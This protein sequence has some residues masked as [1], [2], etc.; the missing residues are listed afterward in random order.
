MTI[1][2]LHQ[3]LTTNRV[4]DAIILDRRTVLS[5]PILLLF[6][7]LLG[8]DSVLIHDPVV[9]DAAADGSFRVVG[10]STVLNLERAPVE[11][12]FQVRG[13]EL[14]V[15]LRL[16]PPEGWMLETS[17][18]SL[19]RGDFAGMRLHG[20]SLS[21]S[22][23]RP[24]GEPATLRDGLILEAKTGV[25]VF[26]PA[27]SPL[28][29]AA[30]RL[31]MRASIAPAI[32]V[33]STLSPL[34]E[35][36]PPAAIDS[37]DARLM[38]H[39]EAGPGTSC[40]V[41]DLTLTDIG[42]SMTGP[43]ITDWTPDAGIHE[44][45]LRNL[46]ATLQVAEREVRLVAGLGNDGDLYFSA[47]LVGFDL[48]GLVDL[49]E[50]VAGAQLPDGLPIPEA[51]TLTRVAVQLDAGT[52][53]VAL[54]SFTV[55]WPATL[56]FA[57]DAL[58]VDNLLVELTAVSPFSDDRFVAVE[59]AGDADWKGVQARVSLYAPKFVARLSM[60]SLDLGAMM[61]LMLGS[62]GSDLGGMPNIQFKFVEAT[63]HPGTGA[64]S[65]RG[66]T[67]V[68]WE[69]PV[70]VSNLSLSDIAIDLDLARDGDGNRQLKGLLSG[71][72]KL[73]DAIC[74]VEHRLP[75]DF[76]LRGQ[77]PDLHLAEVIETLCGPVDVPG[78]DMPPGVFDVNLSDLY[79][80]I[81]P[82]RGT[83]ALAAATPLGDAE[84]QVRR[85][86][87]GR[88]GF[89]IGYAPATDWK[90]SELAA[91][92]AVL[93]GLELSG[94]TLI[95]SSVDDSS[96]ALTTIT[97]SRPDIVLNRDQ[98]VSAQSAPIPLDVQR[99]LNIYSAFNLAGSGADQV[100]GLT[101]LQVFLGVS[102][103]LSDLVLEAKVDG[104]FSIA[105]GVELGDV[106]FRLR[107]APN[108]FSITLLG[109]IT[110]DIE[111][112]L[113]KFTGGLEVQPRG[114]AMQATMEGT[115]HEPFG[116]PRLKLSDVALDLGLS[117]SPP[118]PTL[119]IA[120]K[121]DLGSF[122]GSAAV[123][124]DTINPGRSMLALAFKRLFLM[125]ILNGFC[126][127]DAVRDLPPEVVDLADAIG[128][129]DVDIY[130]APMPTRIG[131]LEFDQ[132][133]SVRGALFLL[134][135][136]G[137]ADMKVDPAAGI[138]AAGSMTPIELG[139]VLAVRGAN[140]D[141]NPSMELVLKRGET[142][143]VAVS[144]SVTMLGMT[145]S[146]LIMMSATAFK[147]SMSGD[148]FG[149]F[150][151]S[152]TA[153]GA[154]IDNAAGI[155]IEATMQNDLF[156]YLS[157]HATTIIDRAADGAVAGLTR[158]QEDVTRLQNEVR[159][160]DRVITTT[161]QQISTERAR[162][163]RKLANAQR[164]LK[165]AQAK[166]NR[167]NQSITNTRRTIQRERSRDQAKVRQARKDVANAQKKVDTLAA[168]I[169][170]TKSG[171]SKLRKK[172][173]DKKRWLNRKSAWDKTWAGPE[174]LAY[175]AAKETEIAALNTKIGGIEAA[176]GVATA[177]LEGAKGVLRGATAG[178]DTFPVDA[179]PR[180]AGLLT[181]RTAA[182]G[183]LKAARLVL[184]G[185]DEAA[186]AVPIDADPRIVGLFTTRSSAL[187]GL[188]SAKGV[189]AGLKAAT[190][191][192]AAAAAFITEHGLGGLI[193]I[194]AISFRAS[195][196][197][198]AGGRVQL[199]IDVSFMRQAVHS[200]GL[201]F[202]F[203]DPLAGAKALAETLVPELRT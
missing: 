6:D 78:L 38:I 36:R 103:R 140:A 128:M 67:N 97:P 176:R 10:R 185:I 62:A 75:G 119:G 164:E 69:I 79:F 63:I 203:K 170:S 27:I 18:P 42:L 65:L 106:G 70:G 53:T 195:L 77:I 13:D 145:R 187:A 116:L 118:L 8:T 156:A 5:R 7:R 111:G 198:A 73:G 107:P 83:F 174:Y 2:A 74:E 24:D 191:G 175:A 150:R 178:I 194:R 184:R 130:V 124:A 64:G 169:R 57:G 55:E 189:L 137:R 165:N 37:A 155:M 40:K 94:F 186:L 102:N 109:V 152:L 121:L 19:A 158:A 71:K 182:N 190:G 88:W 149:V 51:L 171:I 50:T 139:D 147:F 134:G 96:L 141:P 93:D 201:D 84:V 23:H 82:R 12:A 115:W 162:D 90:P 58:S 129:E 154:A 151:G 44:L 3:A 85:N 49:G 180:I 177:A 157:K 193:D 98:I 112:D 143:R 199:D 47:S 59:V 104:H 87:H 142:P 163:R 35:A 108:A 133:L 99:G 32:P 160:L 89:V 132:G 166:V 46:F 86:R 192:L 146:V 33:R 136:S 179:D 60:P 113:L 117:F 80:L 56:T 81:A 14:A 161:R 173:K 76:Q 31:D 22:S 122:S 125:D 72:V 197:S 16:T 188:E 45:T 144:G 153:G 17:F 196:D 68:P 101:H 4:G 127:G 41:G 138:D 126:N 61:T 15:E 167:I 159:K 11:A 9:G 181:A 135:F 1:E 21:L 54:L 114:A 168:E 43:F 120:G 30:L 29:D 28:F 172:I 20:A 95:V 34:G 200:L 100:L 52:M 92:L 66:V 202:N 25:S 26:D 91:S 131:E 123:R 110:A 183:A 48:G 148:L 39:A 105:E